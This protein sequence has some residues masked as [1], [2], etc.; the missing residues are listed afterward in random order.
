MKTTRFMEAMFSNTD[1]DAAKQVDNDIKKAQAKGEVEDPVNN[2]K[3]ENAGDGN[4]AITDKKNGEVTLAK[5]ADDAEDTYDLIAV[6]DGEL[7]RFLHPSV[8]GYV[9]P[10]RQLGAPDERVKDHYCPE[11]DDED[12]DDEENEKEFSVYT[13]NDVVRRIFSDQE[14]CERIFSEVLETGEETNIG[15]LKVENLDEEDALRVTNTSSGDSAVVKYDGDELVVDEKATTKEFGDD[16]DNMMENDFMPLHIVGADPVNHILID[17]PVYDHLAAKELVRRLEEDGIENVRI[18]EDFSD[19]RDYAIELLNG[20]GVKSSD[21]VEEP[22]QV[23]YSKF[24]DV[25]ATRYYSDSTWTE[26][27][28][29]TEDMDGIAGVRETVVDA[30]ENGDQVETD[31]EVVT[32]I[33]ATTAVIADKESDEYTKATV[34]DDDVKLEE[35]DKDEAE[36]LTKN[37]VSEDEVDDDDEDDEDEDDEEEEKTYSD[38]T[39]TRFF[40][41]GEL[42]TDYMVRLYSEDSDQDAIEDA[43][44]NGDQVETDDEII[45]PIDAKTAVVEDKDKDEYTKV[46]ILDDD[47]MNLHPIDEDEAEELTKDLV[48]DGNEEDE[49][50]ED[51]EDEEEKKFS[52]I[53]TN[54]AETRF[55]SEDEPMTDYMIRLYSEDSDQNVIEDAIANG[56]QIETDDE[57]ITPIDAKTAVVEDKE[58]DEFTKATIVS[59]G[60][61]DV[62]PIDEDEAKELTSDLKVEDSDKDEDKEKNFSYTLNKFFA[63]ALNPEQQDPSALPNGQAPEENQNAENNKPSVEEVEDKAVAAVQ[64]IKAAAEEAAATIMDAKAAPAPETEPN[65][66]E[67]QFS[68]MQF[69]GEKTFGDTADKTFISWLEYK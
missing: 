16:V 35:I 27:R 31:S 69:L 42:M 33:D 5:K 48:T 7:E 46:T 1:E 56:D 24:G 53:Y 59:D 15:D 47:I 23:E 63:E 39:E 54:D 51:D 50:E 28:M 21:D 22:K 41:E 11:C 12:E 34:T 58:K 10:G 36:D 49:D 13:D 2:L 55:F 19:A 64:S 14:F 61:I 6:P 9:R 20:L 26:V 44:E 18:F 52:E 62:K 17:A 67:A 68:D 40:S 43:I 3:Y 8:N 4:V 25:Y 65:L 32:P 57:I 38:I 45:T 30:V 60:E 66:Q 37:L 29:F